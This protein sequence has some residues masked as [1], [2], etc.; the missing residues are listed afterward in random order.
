MRQSW[1]TMTSVSARHIILTPTQPVGSGQPQRGSNP[2]PPDQRSRALST[3]LLP[4]PP[5]PPPRNRLFL[6]WIV[7]VLLSNLVFKWIPNLPPLFPLPSIPPT[8]LSSLP[9]IVTLKGPSNQVHWNIR[10]V[11]SFFNPAIKENV[12][13]SSFLYRNLPHQSISGMGFD[14]ALS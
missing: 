2:V 5:P 6:R 9:P 11:Y 12:I 13:Y 4:P 1:E 7:A 14:L 10:T 8:H 3:E